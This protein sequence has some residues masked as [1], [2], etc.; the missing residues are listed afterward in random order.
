MAW[1]IA[2]PALPLALFALTALLPRKARNRSV[3]FSIGAA[4]A[5][6]AVSAV[7][8]VQVLQSGGGVGIEFWSFSWTL[9]TI[10]GRPLD[11]SMSVDALTAVLVLVVSL[12][13]LCVQVFS[14]GYLRDDERKGW[15]FTIVSLFTAAM[16]CFVLAGD[17]LLAFASWEI[18]GLCSYFLIGFW[19]ERDEP[20]RASQK[21]FIVTRVGDLG[22]LLALAVIY[23]AA[24]TF[25]LS[26]VLA[27]APS[28]DPAVSVTVAAGLLFA[29]MG[30]SA[31][32]PLHVWLP[33]AMAGPTSASA[34]IHAATMVAAGVLLVARTMPIFVVA[35]GMLMAAFVVGIATSFIGGSIACVQTDVKKVLAY[36]TISQLG[37]MFAILGVAGVAA[38]L[39]HLVTHA[40]FKSLLFLGSGSIIHAAGTQD[41]SEMGGLRKRLP[42]TWLTFSIGSLALAGMAPLSGFFSKDEIMATFLR[43]DIAWAAAAVAAVSVLTAFYMARLYFKVFEGEPHGSCR[44]ERDAAMLAPLAV[45][46]VITVGLGWL[47]PM[48]SRLMGSHGSWP[49][50]QLIVTSLAVVALGVGL[51]WWV[52]G[53]RHAPVDSRAGQGEPGAL[54]RAL[55]NKLYFD[56]AYDV[57]FVKP[58]KAM[59]RAIASF[60]RSGIDG[61]IN[62]IASLARSAGGAARHLQTGRLQS[63]Q[64]L[65]LSAI[66]VLVVCVLVAAAARGV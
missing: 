37:L 39:F 47:S 32:M 38:A 8:L 41:M 53:K 12:V 55:V 5:S 42:F 27:A 52:Y 50:P 61:V 63:Y 28:W 18:M 58:F 19:F 20:R 16:L 23:R 46:A 60:D 11:L 25:D 43:S 22:F 29:A 10:G 6:T 66:V 30:K 4:L 24:G 34:L 40:F 15:F 9:A 54:R 3:G 33:D 62:G 35:P 64:R 57:V 21:A 51:G 26:S 17:L 1:I 36:S 31:Q 56:A 44:S 7:L 49:T 65:T 2:I 48:F 13:G 14:L 45:L 59:A